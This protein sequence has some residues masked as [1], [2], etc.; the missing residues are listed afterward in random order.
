MEVHE[1]D[2]D[3]NDVSTFV[4][5]VVIENVTPEI[6]GGRFPIKRTI[7]EHVEVTADTY[8]DGH[9]ILHAVLLHRP[10]SQR[11]WEEVPM[12]PLVND[13][14]RAEFIVG[15]EGL[16]LYTLKAWVDPFQTWRRDF[17]KKLEAGQDISVDLLTGVELVQAAAR[18]ANG[19]D[20]GRLE[21]CA[22]ELSRLAKQ[23]LNQTAQMISNGDLNALMVLHADRSQATIYDKELTVVVDRERARF[24]TWYEMFPRSCGAE[25]GGHGIFQD[26]ERR[27]EYV[28]SMGFDVLYLPPIHPIGRTHR[29]GK[30]NTEKATPEDVGSPWA[31]G[32]EEGG[33][34]AIDSKL[35]TL[36]D[37][38]RLLARAK[39]F[40][41]EVALDLAF[42]CAPDHPYVSEHK[43]WFR[44]RPDGSC[45]VCRKPSQKV[46]GH[47]PAVFRK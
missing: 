30:N 32:S 28:S 26:C 2:K 11:N 25:V 10:G 35:G 43:E 1:L 13:S 46:P 23:N 20:A 33:H 8:A 31:I 3:D 18:R 15:A 47:L 4:M 17:S 9:D 6:Q 29:K 38:R 5:R 14:W 42:Q 27:L 36:E 19:E 7:G 41:L 24:S 45:A 39:E 37:F 34:K 16:H 21:A 44:M 22:R 12:Q 40:G